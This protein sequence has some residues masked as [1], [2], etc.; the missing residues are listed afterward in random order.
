MHI[1]NIVLSGQV[2][3]V[4]KMDAALQIAKGYLEQVAT[5]KDKLMFEQEHAAARRKGQ[6]GRRGHQPDDRRRRAAGHAAGPGGGS[7]ARCGDAT[8]NAQMNAM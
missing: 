2:T 7:T 3:S 8:C 5:A 4:V 1:A 6:E